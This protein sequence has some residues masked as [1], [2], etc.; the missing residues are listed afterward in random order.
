M[1]P[2]EMIAKAAVS[3]RERWP[4]GGATASSATAWCS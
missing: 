3:F 1:E 2:Q 4:Y